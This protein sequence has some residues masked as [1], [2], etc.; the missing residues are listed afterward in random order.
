VCQVS[1]EDELLEAQERINYMDI[2]TR[3]FTEPDLDN[4]ATAFATEA[5]AKEKRRHFSRY[6]LWEVAK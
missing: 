2:K 3:L 4:Q 1:S 5:V 6:K